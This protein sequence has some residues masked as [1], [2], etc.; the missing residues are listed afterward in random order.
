MKCTLLGTSAANGIPAP[1]CNCNHC[2]NTIRTRPSLF[3]E[4]DNTQLLFDVSPDIKKQS[5][6]RFTNIDSIFATH[7]HHDHITG[8]QE[9]NHTT[10]NKSIIEQNLNNKIQSWFGQNYDLYCSKGTRKFLNESLGYI[11]NNDS[12][13]IITVEDAETISIGNIKIT[14]F[15]AEHSIGYMGY[16]IENDNKSVVYHPDYGKLRT[17]HKFKNIDYFIVDGSS[18]LGYD[19]HGTKKEL[20]KL[21][22]EVNAD[23]LLFTNVSEHISQKNTDELKYI[24]EK[25]GNA[26]VDD[27]YTF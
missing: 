4:T 11:M 2:K 14:P 15:I 10:L 8:L 19:I 21:I 9:I 6:G 17:K 13:N 24:G 3:I 26:V 23:Q 5:Q 18:A 22:K 1:L 12:I 7:H 20:Q 27:G 25:W 16:H